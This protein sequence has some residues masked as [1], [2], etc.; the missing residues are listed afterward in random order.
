MNR[1]E[2]LMRM[3]VSATAASLLAGLPSLAFGGSAAQ[4]R[5]RLVFIFSPNGVI[6]DHF[7]P[8]T[9][10][11]DYDIKRI[12]SPLAE[13]QDQ[14]LTI[15]GICNQIKGDGDGHM[16]GIGCLLTGIELFPGDVQ[17]GS[18]TPAGWSMGISVDQHIK[19]RLQAQA[20]TQTR[21]GSLEFGVMVPDRADTWTRMSYAGP[22]QPVAPI[23]DPYQ[24]FDKL[25]G[26]T[27]NRQ[28]L[29]SVL[30][31]LAGDFKRVSKMLST[32]DRQLLDRHLNMVRTVEKDLKTEFAAAT[33]N[34]GVQHAVP[35]LPPNI[36]EQND[37]MPQITEM[38]VE[39][40]VN[41][42]LADFARVATFQITNSVGQPRMRWLDI[43]EGHH[44]LSHEPDSNEDSYEK[45]IRINTWYAEQVAHMARRMKETPDPSG[46][47]SLLDNTTIVWTN[48][49][50]KGNSHTRND[51]PFVMIGGGLDFRQG[52]AF[53]FKHVPHNRLLL[54]ILEGFGMP[55]KTFGN[56]DFC[57]DG[58]LTGLI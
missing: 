43:N 23:S 45:L 8:E 56:P 21:F 41:S 7:W 12:L 33:K 37:N 3:G 28:M 54:S 49:L 44:G 29:A 48:E 42:F 14:M 25:Y 2:F 34:D 50:G 16:R 13:F 39:L 40:L 58:P 6:P 57:G 55:E 15:K 11:K 1:R 36:E 53:D 30:D 5:R 10:G 26:Q 52:E 38:Q 24:M 47:G 31:D 18:D 46:H 35:K 20:D 9:T 32:E 27:K 4:R 22:N 19:N 51:I 17:G